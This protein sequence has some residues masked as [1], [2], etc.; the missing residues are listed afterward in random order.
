MLYELELKKE[1]SNYWVYKINQG[2]IISTIYL[3]KD[4][5]EKLDKINITIA[6]KGE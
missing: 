1:T 6:K 2:D 4:E 5:F 3:K